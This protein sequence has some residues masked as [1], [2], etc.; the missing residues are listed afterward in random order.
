[1]SNPQIQQLIN[2]FVDDLEG[3]FRGQALSAAQDALRQALGQVGG[4]YS[5]PK[6][7]APRGR[8]AKASQTPAPTAAVAA[9]KKARPGKKAGKRIRRN[10]AD[11]EAI[12]AKIVAFVRANPGKR[13]EEIKGALGLSTQDWAL[14]LRKLIDAG[15]LRAKGMKRATTYTA[16]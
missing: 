15:K 13:G 6:P 2:R 3:L 11:L 8:P 10:D 14:P 7:S 16:G 4:A 1:M 9:P 5:A 12:G